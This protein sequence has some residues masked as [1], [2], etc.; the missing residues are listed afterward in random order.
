MPKSVRRYLGGKRKEP[1]SDLADELGI[2]LNRTQNW[3]KLVPDQ[4]EKAFQHGPGRTPRLKASQ[5]PQDS[6]SSTPGSLRRTGS[7]AKS[8]KIM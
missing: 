3:V 8:W 2:R 1:V 6:S 7:S 5:G 4:T